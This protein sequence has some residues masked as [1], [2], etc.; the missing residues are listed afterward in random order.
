M[1]VAILGGTGFLGELLTEKEVKS[2]HDVFV[3]ARNEGKLITLKEKFPSIKI[4]AG[5]I[6]D[7]WTV[8]T[9]FKFKPDG[10]FLLSA[11][12]HVGMAEEEV[13]QCV[14]SN[15]TGVINV[16][17]AT[18]VHKP[19]FVV[20][21]ST[22]KAAK[23]SG[24]YGATKLLGERLMKEAEEL[25]S[26]TKYRVVRY[27]NVLY[28]TGSVLCK[29]KD[30]IEKGEKVIVT[31][32]EATRFFWTR[33]EALNLKNRHRRYA[34]RPVHEVNEDMGLIE[35]YEYKVWRRKS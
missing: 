28:S 35:R 19:A 4:L 3:V 17:N 21:T 33:E 23:V 5:D 26:D 12:K 24:V 25:N 34:I 18:F 20:L 14:K 1:R 2:G 13:F 27:G 10:V 6:A 9:V 30:K 29:W 31:D 15:V 8:A 32:G 22:D 11:F 7:P 16:L